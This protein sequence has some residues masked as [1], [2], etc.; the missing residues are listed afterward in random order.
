M[1][2]IQRLVAPWIQ[3][4]FFFNRS[5]SGKIYNESLNI[6]NGLTD[7]VIKDKIALRRDKNQNQV[8]RNSK[9]AAFLDLLLDEH[10]KDPK[11][12]SELEMRWE[13]NTFIFE[14]H[15][16]TAS[17]IAFAFHAIGHHPAV[18]QKIQ[19]ELDTVMSDGELD[20]EGLKKL[21]YLDCVVKET[22]RLYPSVPFI[23][24]KVRSDD[25]ILGEH[26]IPIGTEVVLW[27]YG[28][29][30]DPDIFLEPEIFRPERFE[31]PHVTRYPFVYTPFSGGPRNCIGQRF[32]NMELKCVLA[33]VLQK[34]TI[35][36]LDSIEDVKIRT[37]L[38]LNPTAKIRMKFESRF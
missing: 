12:L 25:L 38:I 28:L 27:I 20:L 18:Q 34:F 15:D 32:A 29:H 2:I 31:D 33:T 3:F 10:F 19:E 37:D 35:N 24:R 4:D 11:R 1:V 8:N 26:K 36:S 22:L 30:R 16:T 21:K 5:S 13:V 6:L 9:R 7:S 14:G 17:A 23:S